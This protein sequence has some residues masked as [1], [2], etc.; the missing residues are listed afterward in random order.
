MKAQNEK[1]IHNSIQIFAAT[2]SVQAVQKSVEVLSKRIDKVNGVRA[3]I[4]E[5]MKSIASKDQ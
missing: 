1:I 5:F 2:Y 3:S 4:T